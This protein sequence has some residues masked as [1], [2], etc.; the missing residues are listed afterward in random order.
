MTTSTVL[1]H[2]AQIEPLGPR[3]LLSCDRSGSWMVSE[4]GRTV[5][6]FPC[7]EAALGS[8]RETSRSAIIEVWQGGEYICCLPSEV[9]PTQF[10]PLDSPNSAFPTV[11]RHANRVAQTLYAVLGPLFWLAL[12]ILA[13]AASLGWRVA[14]L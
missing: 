13:L 14:L 2:P 6:Q 7:F 8:A 4:T 10:S 12:M 1:R 5:R 3:V 9:R 11:E